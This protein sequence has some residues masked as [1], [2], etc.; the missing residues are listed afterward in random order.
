[1]TPAVLDIVVL[2]HDLPDQGLRRGDLGTVVELHSPSAF[3]VEFVAASGAAQ[4]LVTLSPSDIRAVADDDLVAVRP[5]S[6]R[7]S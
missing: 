1:M 2:T 6:A 5:V 7:A 4:A 3:M